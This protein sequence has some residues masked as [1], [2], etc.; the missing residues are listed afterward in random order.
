MNHPK[1][2]AN[3]DT[4]VTV[5]KIIEKERRDKV[6]DIPCGEGALSLKVKGLGFEV[7][8]AD[9][10]E[11]S[12]IPKNDIEFVKVDMNTKL[13]FPDKSFGHIL[14]VEGI[15]HL[16]NHFLLIRE[17]ARIIKKDGIL[18]ITTPNT[19]NIYNR[20]RFLLFGSRDIVQDIID[21][22]KRIYGEEIKKELH[23]PNPVDFPYLRNILENNGFRIEEISF[24]RHL[25][26]VSP[27]NFIKSVVYKFVLFLC[28][29][30]IKIANF[31]LKVPPKSKDNTN[32][33]ILWGENLIIKARKC[34]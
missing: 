27:K 31:I 9:I 5:V 6:L 33:Y 10:D 13:P 28:W 3:P 17:F 7:V 34:E 32:F 26:K 29:I 4:H 14:C 2:L 21:E 30:M 12:F 16:E 23:H 11:K 20:L 22:R 15:E 18:I 1:E 25:Y 19:L 8:A 24:N